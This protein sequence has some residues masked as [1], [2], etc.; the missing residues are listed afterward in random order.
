MLAYPPNK[1]YIIH[2]GNTYIFNLFIVQTSIFIKGLYIIFQCRGNFADIGLQ[3]KI[4]RD[5]FGSEHGKGESDG[6]TGRFAQAL[7]RAVSVPGTNFKKASDMVAFGNENS[8]STNTALK[9]R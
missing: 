4:Q 5:Y 6:E 3:K 9:K 1:T 7:L 8:R 2:V